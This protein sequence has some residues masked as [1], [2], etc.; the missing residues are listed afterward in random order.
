MTLEQHAKAIEKL[1]KF[2][3]GKKVQFVKSF[4][5]KRNHLSFD[6]HGI[7]DFLNKTGEIVNYEL[8]ILNDIV[9]HKLI[10]KLDDGSMTYYHNEKQNLWLCDRDEFKFL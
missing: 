6:E 1:Y 8:K 10:V 2:Y 5:E 3:I 4:Y 7:D 9:Y